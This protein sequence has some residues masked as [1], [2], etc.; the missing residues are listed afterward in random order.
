MSQRSW[1][2][3]ESA[4]QWGSLASCLF[5]CLL[6]FVFFLGSLHFCRKEALPSRA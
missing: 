2:L 3:V 5:V 4:L 6:A 1:V